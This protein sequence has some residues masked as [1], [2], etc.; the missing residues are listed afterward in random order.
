MDGILPAAGLASRMRG[1]PKFLLPCNNE[2]LTLIESHLNQMLKYCNNIWI[3]TRPDLVMLLDS[4][5]LS[6]ERVFI[7]PVVS[8]NM[9]QTVNRILEISNAEKFQLIMP[10]TFFTGELPYEK[11][12]KSFS[13]NSI[14][15]LALWKIR[16]EQKGKLGQ[17]SINNAGKVIDIIDKK[18]NCDYEYSWGAISFNRKL[19]KYISQRDPHVGYAISEAV[20]NEEEING[21]LINGQYFDCGTPS[22]YL[23]LLRSVI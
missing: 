7:I 8:E 3:A 15:H 10:D 21:T 4:I 17:V 22:E 12:V 5:N 2:Y 14:A 16:E 9:N 11:L 6:N 20:I 18:N 13:E 1:I 23:D 19:S